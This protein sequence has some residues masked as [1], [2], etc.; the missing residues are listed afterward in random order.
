MTVRIDVS[1]VIV[2]WAHQAV[3]DQPLFDYLEVRPFP[4]YWPTPVR[5]IKDDC[6]A[7]NDLYYFMAGAED[8]MENGF[9]G[10]GNTESLWA[11]AQARN[12]IFTDPLQTRAGYDMVLYSRVRRVRR[13]PCTPL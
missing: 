9:D 8:P 1:H 6:G 2:A 12:Q 10:E 7:T 4:L 11:A 13:A 3:K 5:R